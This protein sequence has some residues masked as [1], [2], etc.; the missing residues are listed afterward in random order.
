MRRGRPDHNRRDRRG[1]QPVPPDRV[2][3]RLAGRRCACRGGRRGGRRGADRDPQAHPVAAG[4]AGGS[5][6]AAATLVACNEFWQTGLSLRANWPSSPRS[7]GSDVPFA[8]VGGTAVGRGRGERL[9][10]ALAAGTYHWALAFGHG[11]LSTAQVYATCDR[12]R[13]AARR[14][15]DRPGQFREP[16]LSTE[17]M[18]A[19]R[20]G[21]PAAG[22]AAADQRP[23]AGRAVAAAAAAAGAGSRPRA[24]RARRDRVGIRAD[25]RVPGQRRR[26]RP[27]ARGRAH[28]LG[29][30][31]RGGAG[32]RPGARRRAWSGPGL[33]AVVNLV[34]LEQAAK[35][36]HERVLLDGV[37]LGVAAGRADRRRR[38]QRGGQDH[39][40]RRP[41][42][43]RRPGLGPDDQGQRRHRSATCRSPSSSPARS[44]EV[45]FGALAEHEW[46]ADPRSR[47]VI[48]AL[49]GG[50]DMTAR[51]RPAVRRRAPPDRA[52][53]AAAPQLR[54]AAAGRA[55]QPSGHRGDHLA[56]RLPARATRPAMW[57]SRTTG[58]SWT[59]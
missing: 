51:R 49:L 39:A 43:H 11:G 22:R 25:L 29:R 27:R 31:P 40:A 15:A 52:G 57:S 58:G 21:D 48:E 37:S 14:L 46:A 19:L 20:S 24:R 18:A 5:A 10:P 8:L 6:D 50:I 1:R 7:L 30:V 41:G 32:Q 26:A 3:P 23:P 36:Y 44:A 4:L 54:P 35:A 28:R 2:E 38:P 55:D 47:A 9:T 45:V 17:L 56:G 16:E 33:P 42:R 13:A 53:G 12:L 34:N 59:R